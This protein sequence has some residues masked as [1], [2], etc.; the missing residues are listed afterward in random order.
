MG[1]KN[2][3]GVFFMG[4]SKTTN[5]MIID[6]QAASIQGKAAWMTYSII[7]ST[8]G[9]SAFLLVLPSKAGISVFSKGEWLFIE[10]LGVI[11]AYLTFFLFVSYAISYYF[12]NK[13]IQVIAMKNKQMLSTLAYIIAV[14]V[15]IFILLMC[16]VSVWIG[17]E[18]KSACLN[19]QREYKTADCVDA[20]ILQLDDAHQDFRSRNS[21]I[22]TLGR[23]GDN[24]A[25]PVIQKYYTGT[26]PDREPLDEVISQYELKKALHLLNGGVNILAPK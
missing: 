21:A 9:I 24:R 5:K 26:I 6:Q 16:I 2:R 10:S 22:W 25:L 3:V 23:L 4:V 12:F 1:T 20:L 17:Y 7:V 19:A 13:K 18:M 15:S 11:F 14:S 8:L